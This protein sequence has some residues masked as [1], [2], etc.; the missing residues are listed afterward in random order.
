[1]T[2]ES[3]FPTAS[4]CEGS[5]FIGRRGC[6][7]PIESC[8][9]GGL[10]PDQYWDLSH[11]TRRTMIDKKLAVGEAGALT[12]DLVEGAY[13][14][15]ISEKDCKT[16]SGVI[17]IGQDHNLQ[18]RIRLSQKQPSQESV[19]PHPAVSEIV[20]SPLTCETKSKSGICQFCYGLD[21]ATK[22]HPSIGSLVG[23]IAG[24]SI[25]ERGTQLSMR[26]FHSGAD[27]MS[28]VDVKDIFSYGKF[29]G[30]RAFRNDH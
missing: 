1:M 18:G 19:T 24:Q 11:S 29:N 9:L 26:T 14:I 6:L 25:G 2:G 3:N 8:F 27:S 17:A 15:F 10:S 23:V 22:R 4:D 21:P 12:R 28:L 20:R 5:I 16:K 13:E 30:R 7:D